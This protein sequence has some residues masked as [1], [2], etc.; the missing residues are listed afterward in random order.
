MPHAV[1]GLLSGPG[2]MGWPRLQA[3]RLQSWPAARI[4]WPKQPSP[5]VLVCCQWKPLTVCCRRKMSEL[6]PVLGV[7][8][9]SAACE[10]GPCAGGVRAERRARLDDVEGGER[11]GA[12][13]GEVGV[14]PSRVGEAGDRAVAAVVRE[15]H[16]VDLR[17]RQAQVGGEGGS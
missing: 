8:A 3:C 11:D 5:A 7:R 1:G 12:E 10:R 16:A 17:R 6:Q 13:A 9:D 4:G 14:A 2:C 15:D